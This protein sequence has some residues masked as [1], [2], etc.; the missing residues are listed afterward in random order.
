VYKVLPEYFEA[1]GPVILVM[2]AAKPVVSDVIF[3][4]DAICPSLGN[5]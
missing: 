3:W 5:T 1:D 2:D 4:P